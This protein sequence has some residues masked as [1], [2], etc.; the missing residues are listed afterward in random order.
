M[1]ETHFLMRAHNVDDLAGHPTLGQD[2]RALVIQQSR[3]QNFRFAQA[4]AHIGAMYLITMS[5][6][7]VLR[8]VSKSASSLVLT[9]RSMQD[10]LQR[11]E[12]GVGVL[13][14]TKALAGLYDASKILRLFLGKV[15][16]RRDEVALMGGYALQ[17]Y[18]G[19]PQ[20]SGN[21][22]LFTSNPDQCMHIMATY[23]RMVQDCF[24]GGIIMTDYTHPFGTNNFTDTYTRTELL[25]IWPPAFAE[26]LKS[27]EANNLTHEEHNKL[28]HTVMELPHA[29]AH[30][31]YYVEH[32]WQLCPVATLNRHIPYVIKPI[33]VVLIRLHED[34][35]YNEL[36]EIICDG[37]DM[38]HCQV[39]VYLKANLTFGYKFTEDA[40]RAVAHRHIKLRPCAFKGEN[41]AAAI[42]VQLKRI[43]KY[44][45][46]GFNW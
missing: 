18:L 34:A 25:Q 45:R 28:K 4:L 19:F 32:S 36:C 12:G 6:R 43:L 21:I 46:H 20:D 7:I 38:E 23:H 13:L 16:R 44:I 1:R 33:N 35:Y 9:T 3:A 42:C 29:S 24:G 15:L 22:D 26:F 14:N 5:D 30:A 17:H 37:F 39:A 40:K 31:P 27:R 2:G 10:W 11:Y 41:A 8:L